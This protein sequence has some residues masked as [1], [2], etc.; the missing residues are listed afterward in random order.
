MNH[1]NF[2]RIGTFESIKKSSS[3]NPIELMP[4]NIEENKNTTTKS[5]NYNENDKINSD[6]VRSLKN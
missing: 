6:L 5:L 1:P 3:S 4:L 2:L